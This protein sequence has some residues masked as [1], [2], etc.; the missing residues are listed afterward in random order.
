VLASTVLGPT[1]VSAVEPLTCHGQVVTITGTDGD[2]QITGTPGNDVITGLAGNDVITGGPGDDV[3][4]GGDENDSV[5]GL[6]GNDV[7]VGNGGNDVLSAGAGRNIVRGGPGQ[8]DLS[9][10]GGVVNNHP[11]ESMDGRT[12]FFGGSDED[13]IRSSRNDDVHA[14][15]GDDRVNG[16][17][18]PGS[19]HVV[20]TGGGTDDL[21][22]RVARPPHRRL[23]SRVRI[24]LARGRL[25]ADGHV[26]RVGGS[27]WRL[28]L[29][30]AHGRRWSIAGSPGPDE[31]R[32]LDR[33]STRD[34]HRSVEMHGRAGDD[35]L[36][37]GSEDDAM[38]G[39]P[40]T[41]YADTLAGHDVCHSI[42]EHTEHGCELVL[43]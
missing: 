7:V 36:Y 23:W 2:D 24:D 34:E 26:A 1:G 13:N 6:G 3:I 33:Y 19:H 39:G 14:G 22:L 9:E 40:G 35:R 8:D 20:L 17:V 42:E 30:T 38:W 28:R 21:L 25:L 10:R 37:G 11:Y 16:G 15:P 43:P 31:L 12:S 18:L 32:V 29:D 41:D 27:V 5:L 4:C